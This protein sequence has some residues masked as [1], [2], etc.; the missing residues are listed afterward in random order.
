MEFKR[1]ELATL[2]VVTVLVALAKE[3]NALPKGSYNIKILNK[4]IN[5]IEYQTGQKLP[6]FMEAVD[7]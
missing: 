7:E 1:L 2:E 4:V 6:D 5:T 3:R